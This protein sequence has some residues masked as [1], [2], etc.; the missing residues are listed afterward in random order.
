[1]SDEEKYLKFMLSPDTCEPVR[2]A[3]A[4]P[5]KTSIVST[6]G[7]FNPDSSKETIYNF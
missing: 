5:V 4:F 2:P 1:M 7:T 6:A 3:S